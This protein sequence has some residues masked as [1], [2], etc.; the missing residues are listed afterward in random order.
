MTKNKDLNKIKRRSNKKKKDLCGA[1]IIILLL[2]G[3]KDIIRWY[4]FKMHYKHGY[5]Q[6][7]FIYFAGDMQMLIDDL[8]QEVFITLYIKYSNDTL[9]TINNP[10]SYIWGIIKNKAIDENKKIERERA[11]TFLV[12][13]EVDYD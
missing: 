6:N 11:I 10:K 13:Q 12:N 9:Y 7:L 5:F 2:S 4:F 3:N 8:F 1:C